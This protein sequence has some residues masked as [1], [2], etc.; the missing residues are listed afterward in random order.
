[1]KL[2]SPTIRL[3]VYNDIARIPAYEGRDLTYQDFCMPDIL[4]DSPELFYGFWGSCY[5][6]Y[7]KHRP[8]EGYTILRRWCD[9][10]FGLDEPSAKGMRVEV[11]QSCFIIPRGYSSWVAHTRKR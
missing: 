11:W 6:M 5:E 4:D 9:E 2:P 1:M 8:H 10:L 7:Q 3:P